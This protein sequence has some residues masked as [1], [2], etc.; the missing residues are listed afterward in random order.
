LNDIGGDRFYVGVTTYEKPSTDS[1][2]RS[3]I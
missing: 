1:K 3:E 2:S